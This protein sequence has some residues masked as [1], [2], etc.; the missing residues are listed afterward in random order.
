MPSIEIICDRCGGVVEGLRFPAT[1]GKPGFTAGYYDTTGLPWSEM[2]N[3]GEQ[4]VCDLC[5]WAD[6]RYQAVY[7]GSTVSPL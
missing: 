4:V 3:E 1:D 5:M 6:P 7:G 2:A